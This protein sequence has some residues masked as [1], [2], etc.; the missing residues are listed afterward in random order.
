MADSGDFN[1]EIDAD[2]DEIKLVKPNGLAYT[3]TVE[4]LKGKGI[5][6]NLIGGG[7]KTTVYSQ[8]EEFTYE[9]Y[10]ELFGDDE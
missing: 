7:S 2:T 3:Y 6:D 9:E 8:N 4:E 10:Q 5:I 1:I